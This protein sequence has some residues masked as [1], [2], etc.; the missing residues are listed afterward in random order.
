MGTTTPGLVFHGE[1]AGDKAG[2]SVSW[3]Q[4]TSGDG[5]DDLLIGAPGATT[6][7]EF[8]AMFFRRALNNDSVY[9]GWASLLG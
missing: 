8:G 5:K 6:L 9:Q 2:R 1:T 4:D 3:W 7:D